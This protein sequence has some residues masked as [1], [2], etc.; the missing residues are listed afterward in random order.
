[1]A[2]VALGI[3]IGGTAVKLG[4]VTAAGD[5]VAEDEIPSPVDASPET[6]ARTVATAARSLCDD[7]TRVGVGCAG[8]VSSAR[9]IVH[10]SPNLPRWKEVGLGDLITQELGLPTRVLN[11]ANA[12]A[13]AEACIGAGRGHTPVVAF[14]LGT[15]V[16]GAIVS[17]GH[18]FGGL[19]GFAGEIGHMSIDQNGPGCACGNRGCLELY[20][21]KRGIVAG[22]LEHTSWNAGLPA[23]ELVGGDREALTPKILV[24]AAQ[25]GDEAAR[26]ALALA[27][28]R[29][30]G[31]LANV[32]NLLDVGIF[33]AGGGVAQAGDLILDPAR[34]VLR[35]RAM[36]P[37]AL[38]A[39][40]V[41]ATLGVRAGVIGAALFGLE[42]T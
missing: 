19:H 6:F 21:G 16:G 25:G 9:G 31:A 3:D 1:M 10:T 12:V 11:D 28:R 38:V 41:P 37:A 5:V 33:V 7:A 42:G 17:E 39:P 40:I 29:L 14:T 18:L 20:V 34:R 8:L 22:Y 23:F 13:L 15:G 2:Q 35:E 4:R 30:G 24:E 36:A 26:D 32:M 27:G